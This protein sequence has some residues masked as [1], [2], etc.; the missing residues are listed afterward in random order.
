MP[1]SCIVSTGMPVR[2]TNRPG[3]QLLGING[4]DDGPV[5]TTC[6][7]EGINKISFTRSDARTFCF[8][9]RIAKRRNIQ[10]VL[11]LI[12]KETDGERFE[13]ALARVC[14]CIGGGAAA[15]NPDSDSDLEVVA[16]SV[17]VNLR[18]PM[19]GSRIKIAGRFKPCIHMGCF[20]LETFVE[21]NQRS[22]KWQCPIC[23]KNYSLEHI[24]IDP[25]FNR[26]T[27]LLQNCGEDVNEL[28]VK[29]DG[30]WRVR[31]EGENRAL[32]QWHL[33]DGTLCVF[34]DIE[35]KT[36][37]D[38]L[39]QTKQEGTGL[40]LGIKRNSDGIWEVSKPKDMMPLS[41]GN[42]APEKFENECQKIM[43]LSVSATGSYRDE[44]DP[45]VNQDG[46]GHFDFST[47]NGQE[48]DS[49]N[50][51]MYN[52]DDRM[53]PAPSKDA[54][55]IVLSDSEED[56]ITLI[57]PE[58]AYDTGLTNA[59]GIPFTATHPGVQ[60][61]YLVDTNGASSL[62]FGN[63]DYFLWPS[64]PTC[65]QTG[66]GFQLFNNDVDVPDALVDMQRTSL[67]CA[68]M[69]GYGLASDGATGDASKAHDLTACPPNDHC[70]QHH[71]GLPHQSSFGPSTCRSN[72]EV[73]SS[74]VDNPLAFAGD[75]PSL[76][77]FL[78]TQPAGM[79][80]QSNLSQQVDISNGTHTD[81]WI[82]LRLGGNDGNHIESAAA[83]G[84]NSRHLF[85]TKE[86][87]MNTLANTASLLLNMN[88][89]ISDK[90]AT[91]NQRSDSSFSHPQQPR[92][93]KP[94][95]YLSIDSD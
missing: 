1:S 51:D 28:D 86:D 61:S 34:T 16:D 19:S 35:V 74:L 20:D 67:G 37:S 22:R 89:D 2:A 36:D 38:L 46:R 90:G 81:D 49:M 45:S 40:K 9:L 6:S 63:T 78:P 64:L 69:N 82:S 95:L 13:D 72:A 76:Q 75:D 27:S 94:R 68:P 25:Y 70:R 12:P 55:I 80:S 32:E 73:I 3:S 4:R 54:D 66:A 71:E 14:R 48:L 87:R 18:C 85:G 83:N 53:P 84:L 56:N 23:L 57:S 24:I 41:S 62:G 77:I 15:E 52:I 93:V 91:N 44:D 7:R 30:S 92:S 88:D 5:I 17:T 60:E 65:S 58:A 79:P 42:H 43:P 50:F 8:G 31:S 10:Q 47:S 29:P 59:T 11:S 33:S 26:I 21:L 39:K